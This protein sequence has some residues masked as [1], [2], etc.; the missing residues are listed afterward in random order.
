MAIVTRSGGVVGGGSGSTTLITPKDYLEID[1][2][3]KQLEKEDQYVI[4]TSET[5]LSTVTF[6]PTPDVEDGHYVILVRGEGTF[7]QL[8][9]SDDAAVSSPPIV[10]REAEISLPLNGD[11]FDTSI[12][13][14]PFTQSSDTGFVTDTFLGQTHEV[15]EVNAGTT[16]AKG[17]TSTNPLT[18]GTSPRTVY[19]QFKYNDTGVPA[20]KS[21]FF[22]IGD[23]SGT[24]TLFALEADGALG[25]LRIHIKNAYIP[26]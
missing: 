13:S 15:F 5:G 19:F 4:V 18:T 23:I 25:G 3:T 17:L 12:N 22:G 24:G 6:P 16:G 21:G 8:V 11:I 20:D 9:K 14:V 2:E 26:Y 7:S 10:V 1:S